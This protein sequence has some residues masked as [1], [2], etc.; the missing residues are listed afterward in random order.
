MP[1]RSP[2]SHSTALPTVGAYT[3]L[4]SRE[5][6][7]SSRSA[8]QTARVLGLRPARKMSRSWLRSG[9]GG[10][11]A[12]DSGEGRSLRPI[13]GVLSP[14]P[15]RAQEGDK[16]RVPYG[17]QSPRDRGALR[18]EKLTQ[19]L[20]DRPYASEG[21]PERATADARRA[22]FP[23]PQ[24]LKSGSR[25]IVRTTTRGWGCPPPANGTA[26]PPGSPDRPTGATRQAAAWTVAALFDQSAD[27]LLGPATLHADGKFAFAGARAAWSEYLTGGSDLGARGK[28]RR[29]HGVDK[30]LER[31]RTPPSRAVQFCSADCRPRKFAAQPAGRE[32]YRRI[33][34]ASFPRPPGAPKPAKSLGI[35]RPAACGT[36]GREGV[37]PAGGSISTAT[38]SNRRAGTRDPR[39]R[40][41]PPFGSI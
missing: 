13:E 24:S 3:E 7:K 19:V 36:R 39:K 6:R 32:S 25:P 12:P 5:R 37:P 20:L 26:P 23:S 30:S 2:S 18:V 35:S 27:G 29:V 11:T 31:S 33:V 15:P 41:A 10:S 38:Q 28:E 9:R 22:E 21:R 17:R 8:W 1:N 16:S 4:V 40:A 14:S 34:S